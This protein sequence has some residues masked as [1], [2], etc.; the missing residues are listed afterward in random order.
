LANFL[1]HAVRINLREDR[2]QLLITLLNVILPLL[3]FALVWTYG[4]AFFADSLFAE[5]IKTPALLGVVLLHLLYLLLRTVEF[6][7]PPATTA[8]EVLTILAFS[9]SVTYLVIEYRSKTKETGYFILNIAFV[10]QAISSIFI[11]D[12]TDVPD[13]LRGYLFGL[14]VS[15]ALL[16]YAA[17]TISAVYGF[18]FLMLYHQI[19]ANRFGVIYKKL[20]NLEMLERMNFTAVK[21][22]FILLSL[23]IVF[24]FIWL[25]Q[26]FDDFSYADPKL[27]GTFIVW[28]LY[29]TSIVAKV[30]AGWNGRRLMILSISGFALA[31]FSLT[32]INVFFTDFHKFH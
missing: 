19:K 7:H 26:A 28:G 31:L 8:F 22:A 20:P 15:T 23:A 5:R 14:H 25:P 30:A 11:E 29:G 10:F 6:D 24:G 4:K 16:G 1:L 2:L 9:V 12:L 17:M 21:M 32:F 3:Y 27:I 13:I 18:L